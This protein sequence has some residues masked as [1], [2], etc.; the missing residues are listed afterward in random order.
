ML[1]RLA[2]RMDTIPEPGE[3]L[4]AAARPESVP[5][6]FAQ[7]RL[8]FIDQL[9]GPSPIYNMAL[10][11]RLCGPLDIAALGAAITDVVIR[12]ETLRTVFPVIEGIPEQRVID[13]TASSTGWH[14]TDASAWSPQRLRE[15][16]T[17]VGRHEFDLATQIPFWAE[18]FTLATDEHVLVLI[19]HHIAAD[20]RSLSPLLHDL[21]T[22][23]SARRSGAAPGWE[24]LAL[25][26]IDYTLWQRAHLGDLADP[27]SAITDQLQFW[28]Q[29]LDGLPERLDLPTDRPYPR[30]AD[31]DGDSVDV[32]WPVELHEEIMRVARERQTT[33]FMVIQA[34]VAAL[35]ASL[36]GS[37]DI[38]VG[39]PVAG[40]SETALEELVGLFVNTV[41]L[42]ISL[43][44]D[45][46]LNELLTQ[47]RE[48]SLD[49]YDYQDV[50]FEAIVERL[51]PTRSLAHHPLFQVMLAWQQ[52]THPADGLTMPGLRISPVY[53]DTRSVQL[54]L[55][56]S[57]SER[58][59]PSGAPAGISVEITYRT[60]VFDLASIEA[61][62]GRLQRLLTDMTA[63]PTAPLSSIDLL[64]AAEHA[65]LDE[66]GNR[67]AL[68]KIA[69]PVS[70]PALFDAQV[71]RTPQ[72]VALIGADRSLTYRQ[73]DQSANRLA[74]A[75]ADAG[76]GVGE[77]VALLLPRSVAA[78]TAIL[79]VIKLG[80]AYL[81][82]DTQQPS[83]RISFMLR[84][85]APKAAITT[86]DLT[87][88]L[89]AAAAGADLAIVDVADP[90]LD[91]FASISPPKPDADQIAYIMYT[92]GT[93]GTP[94]GVAITH[95]NVAQL[96]ETPTH[97]TAAA[98]KVGAQCHSYSFDFSVW[99]M[100]GPL[101]HG[102]RLV[103]VP[104]A[105]ARSALD[106]H[107]LLVREHVDVLTQTPSAIGVLPSPGLESAT[108]VLLG[109]VCT[110]EL[111]NRWAPGRVMINSYGPTETTVWVTTSAPLVAGSGLPPIGSPVPG[112]ALF[113]LDGWLRRVPL[114]VVGELYVAG[115]GVGCGY[116]RR[117]GLTSA[118]FLACPFATGVRMYR[119][120]D[121][122][123]WRADGQLEYVGR[124]DEQ[125]KI[126]G[127]RIELGDV[128]AALADAAGVDQAVV[129]VREDRRGDRR[130]VGYVTKEVQAD[131]IRS[132]L[133]SRLPEYM[134]PAAV[135][136]VASLPMTVNG[137]LDRRA[138]PAPDYTD[139]TAYRAP[140]NAVEETLAEIY[141][142]VL[143]LQRVGVDE[144]F[145]DL[146]GNSLL[147]MQVIAA[148]RRVLKADVMVRTLFDAPSVAALSR[149]LRQPTNSP[150]ITPVQVLRSGTGAPLF[151]IHT[152]GGLS[153]SYHGLGAYLNCPLVGIQ[154]TP[155]DNRSQPDSIRSMAKNYAYTLQSLQPTGPYNLLGWS[156]GGVV[157]HELAVE[158]R[159]Q[160][161]VVQ[162]LILLDSDAVVDNAASAGHAATGESRILDNILRASGIDP[163]APAGTLN[164]EQAELQIPHSPSNELMETLAKNIETNEAFR[165]D[166]VP[167]VFD[168][169]M[170]IFVAARSSNGSAQLRGWRP[171]VVGNIAMHSVNCT[172]YEMLNAESLKLFGRQLAAELEDGVDRR[173]MG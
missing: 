34:G 136:S 18:F 90:L 151:C 160:G 33:S 167:A 21:A 164:D 93:T 9:E 13:V 51:N 138:L 132:K 89:V 117:A 20:G 70:I 163:S 36:S 105:V 25:Q 77:V 76:V 165:S 112:A 85:A 80:A 41:V 126:R 161:C 39:V 65:R 106:L 6:S 30:A 156:F 58:V 171:Y 2:T 110:A 158:L 54:D 101:L 81:P 79:A 140:T 108:L 173:S 24:E 162:R 63:D 37:T 4:R 10:G 42:R 109:E 142:A 53:V 48:R 144:S 99:E 145:F 7:R 102:G 84:D 15:A 123:R 11:L 148:I 75:L 35:L 149:Q 159:R 45:P 98:G 143:G 170:V 147:A 26:Y 97:F 83:A 61:L 71:A 3:P 129:I 28:E 155:R 50:P 141:G 32:D 121:L 119:T 127:Y 62:I 146:G 118:R 153:W 152:A 107:A 125:V 46:N 38:A 103:V 78:I 168:G 73:L 56:L 43:A 64:D 57:F 17:A 137:K 133:A 27:E 82:I 104:D 122:V 5:L 29:A 113:V 94:K 1:R 172:H 87:P 12:H 55:A 157:A 69:A 23:Y 74:H 47:V 31:H 67:A 66:F 139:E 40:R 111:A 96:L 135:V 44:G 8:W 52:G 114:G 92:S 59:T 100:W 131:R 72:A 95:G 14:G 22:A 68:A 115:A 19:V 116:W 130:L 169:D 150:E 91:T 60:D 154:Q 166:H 124:S 128:S 49:A 120:G 86:A 134:L 16:I 88:V